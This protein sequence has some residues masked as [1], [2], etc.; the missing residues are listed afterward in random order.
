L[1]FQTNPRGALGHSGESW[2]VSTLKRAFPWGSFPWF[3]PFSNITCVTCK[4]R[5]GSASQPSRTSSASSKKLPKAPGRRRRNAPISRKRSFLSLCLSHYIAS[6][7]QNLHLVPKGTAEVVEPS[8][9]CKKS[10]GPPTPCSGD[11]IHLKPDF[12][13][14]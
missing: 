5:P 3:G 11:R 8:T 7:H 2:R 9:R 13:T 12:G 1:V 4:K 10:C 6:V 14:T